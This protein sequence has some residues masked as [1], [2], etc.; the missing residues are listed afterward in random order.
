MRL[1]LVVD[2][3]CELKTNT[4]LHSADLGEAGQ[5]IPKNER[6]E[7][8]ADLEEGRLLRARMMQR[9]RYQRWVK[10]HPQK[11]KLEQQKRSRKYVQN[12]RHEIAVRL[13]KRYWDNP[14]KWRKYASDWAKKN[15]GKIKAKRKERYSKEP[16]YRLSVLSHNR[17]RQA[18]MCGSNDVLAL[19]AILAKKKTVRCFY[20]KTKL[21]ISEMQLEHLNP[22]A[23]GGKHSAFNI[24][25]SCAK[26]NERKHTKNPNDFIQRGQ[27]VLVY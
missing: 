23:A 11:A 8:T 22:L 2:N 24:V 15:W 6:P 18:K 16:Q 1:W 7:T 19:T 21:N 25:P 4:P 17:K 26:C 13:R 3:L 10:K 14:E 12:H 9:V 5:Q 27:L 20:C